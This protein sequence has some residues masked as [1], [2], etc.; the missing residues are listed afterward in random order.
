MEEKPEI[1]ASV[2]GRSLL[3]GKAERQ[4][5]LPH[6]EDVGRRT[7]K[8]NH[9]AGIG[10][11]Q[12]HTGNRLIVGDQNHITRNHDGTHEEHEHHLFSLE[13]V[14]GEGI[15]GHGAG[16]DTHHAGDAGKN[17]RIEHE[18]AQRRRLD[19]LP[20][21]GDHPVLRDEFRRA[22]ENLVRRHAGNQKGI[23]DRQDD[24]D[25]E[26]DGERLIEG[27]L[28]AVFPRIVCNYEIQL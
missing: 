16:N 5:I 4:E 14:E 7:K 1:P 20:V 17:Q 18:P 25:A 11:D 19:G 28:N 15:G 21:I 8:Y 9:H 12:T 24:E 6:H 13:L 3:D 27:T 2:D 22:P 23:D 10:I 26:H